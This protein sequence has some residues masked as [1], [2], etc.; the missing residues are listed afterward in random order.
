AGILRAAC[1]SQS[2]I[3]DPQSCVLAT[4]GNLN[5]DVGLPLML[6]EL[7]TDHRYAVI[8][9]GMNHVG[10]IAYLTR[11]TAPSVALVNNAGRAH[12]EF[13]GSEEA[14]ARAKGEIYEGL[15]ADGIAVINADDAHAPL[16]REMTAGRQRIEFGFAQGEVTGRYRLGW[17]E[18]EIVIRTPY[19]EASVRM[20]APG[21]HNVS[22]ALAATAAAVALRI[23]T[24][25]IATGLTGF[26]GVKGRLQKKATRHGATLIDDTYNANPDSVAAAIAVLGAAPGTK[27]LV[28]GDMGELG[29][30][31]PRFHADL[32]TRA[33]AGGID[34][35]FTLGTL[36]AETARTFGSG[37]SHF[38]R[39][40][41]LLSALEPLLAPQ[42]AVL[43]KGSR[44]MKMERVVQALEA[45]G[46]Q[47]KGKS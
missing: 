26:A 39:V 28:L 4:R 21:A 10:E 43:V 5:N 44:F 37:A 32:G 19:G 18:S 12:I 47:D 31:A 38:E 15:A 25:A 40:E 46:A 9:M 13:L 24:P 16:W 41:D 45:G 2:S 6:L 29:A 7:R 22:N 14:I 30:N 27:I 33:H 23:P 11:L 20:A 17:L 36:S 42:V 8:E 3:P 35:L 1:A 34:R